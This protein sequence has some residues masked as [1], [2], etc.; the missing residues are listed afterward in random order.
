MSS[1]DISI[2]TIL[3]HEGGWVDHPNDPGGETN[4]GISTLIVQR[5]GITNAE[6]G[7]PDGRLPGWMKA[8][9]VDAA[10]AIY[11]KLF[12]DRYK[13]GSIVD[14][15]AATKVFDCAVNCGPGRAGAM[16]QRAANA[17][18]ATLAT[19]GVMGP[20]SFAA[21]N[22]LDGKAFVKAFADQMRAYY[23]AIIVK[24]PKL[25]VFSKNW[26]RRAS[27]GE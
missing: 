4:F 17:L 10:V 3:L 5:E 11:K 23:Q 15:T 24:N 8:M 6:L 16:A 12:W 1:F 19:D 7:L 9:K 26:M 14:Q 20:K 27:W 18:G 2:K 25:Q 22:A 13:Y 21:I